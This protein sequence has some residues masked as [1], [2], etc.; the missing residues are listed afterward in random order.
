M[1]YDIRIKDGATPML[2]ELDKTLK[3]GQLENA[4]GQG[5]SNHIRKWFRTRNQTHPNQLGGRRT[6]FWA[7]CAR[8]TSYISRPGM[9]TILIA[10]VGFAQR[11]HGGPIQARNG[12][13]LTIPANAEAYGRRARDMNLRFGFAENKY[14][15]L[16]PALLKIA[17]DKRKRRKGEKAAKLG[18]VM[19]WLTPRVFQRAD[20]SVL[21]PA[22]EITDAAMRGA[23][24]YLRGRK[25][26]R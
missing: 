22:Q 1:S 3:G 11:L 20:P 26:L 24:E 17:A 4:M 10:K 23:T 25:D 16:M 13:Y 18:D 6:N 14:G 2:Q 19:F 8:S 9:A 7:A 5:A 12:K 15:N 21:P